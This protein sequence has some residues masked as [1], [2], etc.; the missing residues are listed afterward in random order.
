MVVDGFAVLRSTRLR[1]NGR[2]AVA[3]RRLL[4]ADE[5]FTSWIS[6]PRMQISAITQP[7]RTIDAD[8]IAV[9]IF[10]GGAPPSESPS[11][12]DELVATGEARG[13]L[14]SLAVT[15]AEGKRWLLVGLGDR[16]EF[17]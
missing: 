6:C 13:S 7:A 4:R 2:A 9:G 3:H 17:T 12:L 1:G 5:S 14:K 10:A 8:T 11:Q 16:T 15:H